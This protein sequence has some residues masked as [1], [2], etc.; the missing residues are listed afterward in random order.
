[1]NIGRSS[2][3]AFSKAVFNARSSVYSGAEAMTVNGTINKAIILTLLVG[4]GASYTWKIFM[5]S[6]VANLWMAIGGIGGFIMA[7]VTSFKKEWAGITAPIYAV[8]QGFFLGGISA[9]FESMYPGIVMQAVGLTVLTMLSML[10][11][12]RTGVIKVTQ[13]FKAGV[14]AA[15]GGIALFYLFSFVL[16]LFGV[17]MSIMHGSGTLSI[18]ISLVVVAVA[19]LN[20]V[21]DFDF[22]DK[23]AAQGAPK[24]FEWYGAFGLM[25]TLIW[26]YIELLRLLAK[27]SS[28]D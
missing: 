17:N 4:L 7:L 3:P 23:A 26:L 2:N 8:L 22:I 25:V 1:M 16:S 6:G 28:R 10:L 11:M 15:T 19:A 20:L 13:K 12:Y 18:V 21:I 14:F 27:L 24:Y 9:I 5:E